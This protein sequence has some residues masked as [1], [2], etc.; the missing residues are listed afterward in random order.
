MVSMGL[1]AAWRARGKDIAVFKKGP[2]FIDAS[3]LSLAARRACRNLDTYLVGE[4]GVRRSFWRY[5]A[6]VDVAVIEGNRGLFDGTDASG[7]HSSARLARLLDAPVVLVVD[8]TKSTRT[9]AASVLGC[10]KMDPEL[11][12]RG[13]ILNRLAGPRH[14]EVIERSIIECCGLEVL[15]RI[16]RG[17]FPRLPER[18]LG[19]V[20]MQEYGDVEGLVGSCRQSAEAYLDID[21]LW[22]LAQEARPLSV[23]AEEVEESASAHACGQGVRVGVVM[24]SSFHFYYPENLEALEVQGG[25]IVRISPSQDALV[26]QVDAL[27]IGGGFPE[28]HAALLAE[29]RSFRASLRQAVEEGLPVYAECGGAMYLGSAIEVGGSTYPMV[30]VF[31]LVFKMHKRPQGHGYTLLEVDKGNPYFEVGRHLKGHEFHYSRVVSW[32]DDELDFVCRVKRGLGFDGRREGLCYKRVFATFTHLHS[33]GEPRWAEAVV[34]NGLA[35]RGWRSSRP[36]SEHPS[37]ARG[38]KCA[39]S[40]L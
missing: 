14:A 9:V 15:G 26:P 29:N 13:V 30:G 39:L 27:Y 2:D 16:P 36:A 33:S 1:A 4:D 20:P 38:E 25:E 5:A 35:Y 17:G 12:L 6:G 18:H 31:P 34:S 8:C 11:A 24:D 22:S 21:A 7:T 28:V 3:W 19:L 23:G 10:Q 32:G 37:E 40:G